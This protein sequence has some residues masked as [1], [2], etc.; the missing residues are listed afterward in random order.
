MCLSTRSG[1]YAATGNQK[2]G[3]RCKQDKP[4]GI[5]NKGFHRLGFYYLEVK[6]QNH[7]GKE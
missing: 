6:I 4:N 7:N 5:I 2:D 1:T 3:K